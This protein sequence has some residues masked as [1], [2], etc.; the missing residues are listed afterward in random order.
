MRKLLVIPLACFALA[1]LPAT[2]AA[3]PARSAASFVDAIGVN[4]HSYYDGTPYTEQWGA[5]KAKL[6]ELGI[7]HVREDIRPGR[8]DQIQHL[9]ELAAMGVKTDLVIGDPGNGIS[10]LDS[11]IALV[12]QKLRGYLDS[13]EGPNE[14]DLR[15]SIGQMTE[16]ATYQRHLYDAIKSDPALSS[17]PVIGPSIV[18]TDHQAALGDISG[19]LDYGNTH[20]YPGGFVPEGNLSTALNRAGVASG[21]KPVM[22]TESGYHNA[23]NTSDGHNPTSEQA[24][25]TYIPRMY[26]EYYRRGIARTYDYELV[27]TWDEPA[28]DDPS[29]H[30][31]LLRSDLSEK[32]AFVALRNMVRILD[33]PGASFSPGN[34]AYSL[35]GSPSDVRQ[36]LLQK[37]DGSFYLALWRTGSVWDPIGR[38]NLSAPSAQVGVNFG[39]PIASAA[40]Y[41]PNSSSAQV[42]S[43][44][45]PGSVSV[46]V[47]PQVTILEVT[48]G[49]DSGGTPPPGEGSEPEP[50]LEPVP[51]P[52]PEPAPEPEPEPEVEQQPA[53]APE[54]SP[55]PE[56]APQPQPAPESPSEPEV[57]PAP[58]SEGTSHG[59]HRS[60]REGRPRARLKVT[61]THGRRTLMLSGRV[62][63][64]SRAQSAAQDLKIQSWKRGW[65]TVGR[66]RASRSGRFVR[67]VR[68][69]AV[70][71]ARVAVLRVVA[72]ASAPS[73]P[74]RVSL[75]G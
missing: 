63:V 19:S 21:S 36:V 15:S 57:E 46:E 52:S 14:F 39:E 26:L 75:A 16:L 47:G 67:R 12:K 44:S 74:V 50:E 60:D 29:P 3:Q 70:D 17:L 55:E 43:F 48:P 13:V 54:T 61:T 30:F 11:R 45:D 35:S 9:A 27:D 59:H 38:K 65:R 24:A 42:A 25:A 6:A 18:D 66:A 2:G 32:P 4:I 8:D 68:V 62:A 37:R 23:L 69:H 28:L 73:Q 49:K 64:A 71:R 33:D 53:P 34:L 56:P 20:S 22:A 40:Q 31:G 58:Q 41:R 1:L 10:G 72:P 51:T 7:S 5:V